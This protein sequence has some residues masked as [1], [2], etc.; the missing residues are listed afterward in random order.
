MGY[1]L[2]IRKIENRTKIFVS[3]LVLFFVFLS[4]SQNREKNNLILK[5][6]EIKSSD[7]PDKLKYIMVK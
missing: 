5:R 4:Y 7:S 6:E 2:K 3:I 1:P